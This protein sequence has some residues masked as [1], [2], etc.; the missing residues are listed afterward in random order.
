M[1]ELDNTKIVFLENL[2]TENITEGIFLLEDSEIDLLQNSIFNG[3]GSDSYTGGAISSIDS[4]TTIVNTSILDSTSQ[5]GAGA[6]YYCNEPYCANSLDNVTF[7]N[8][9]AVEK[10]GA[11][12]YD[13]FRP[14]MT[15]V[16]FS[17]NTAP[18][19]PD[20]AS[21][22][23]KMVINGTNSTSMTLTDVSSGETYEGAISYSFV[24]FDDQVTTDEMT[25]SVMIT[26]IS[27]NTSVLDGTVKPVVDG[28][29]TFDSLRFIG[30]SGEEEVE[31]RVTTNS[32]DADKMMKQFGKYPPSN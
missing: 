23:V 3:S 14:N 28:V 4:N 20:I 5:I 8:C 22:P 13:V 10:G 7:M 27:Q 17:D 21:Y 15:N 11:I 12:F 1:F 24:D 31:F 29:A 32:I 16:T 25:G 18:Y 9:N 2:Y 6:R 30:P 26:P 19:G